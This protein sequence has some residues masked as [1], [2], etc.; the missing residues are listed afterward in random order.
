VVAL[1]AHVAFAERDFVTCNDSV[2]Y[3]ERHSLFL[4]MSLDMPK[5]SAE[6]VAEYRTR[7]KTVGMVSLTLIVPAADVVLFN[8]FAA[9]RR[10][11]LLEGRHP[12]EAPRQPLS[13]AASAI[14][15]AHRS[16]VP[17]RSS[18]RS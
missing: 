14:R 10:E 5:T 3:I 7:M 12:A 13:H 18:C 4:A 1:E 8:Q 9:Q 15:S 6:R 2:R 11:K 16:R 17:R